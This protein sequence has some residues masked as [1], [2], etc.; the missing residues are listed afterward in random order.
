[1]F[2]L[3]ALVGI[4]AKMFYRA[5]IAGMR[6]R[7]ILNQAPCIVGSYGSQVLAG[8]TLPY[9]MLADVPETSNAHIL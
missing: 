6:Q 5:S 1:M 4:G 2:D 9:V 7:S 8:W 3:T